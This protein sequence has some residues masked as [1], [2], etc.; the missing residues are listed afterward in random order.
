MLFNSFIFIILCIVTF[1]FYYAPRLSKYQVHI[2]VLSSFVFYSYK[3]FILILLLLFS[4]GLNIVV[5]YI[6]V[7]GK[8]EYRKTV[9]I[10]GVVVNLSALAFFKYSSLIA[11]TLFI[12]SD[13]IGQ[14]LLN[15]PL[16]IGI[17][18]FTFEGISLFKIYKLFY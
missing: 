5:S 8:T 1:F 17:S 16:P 3:S 12:E 14:F 2:L 4:A 7:N 9:A 18:F 10:L 15:I 13:S 11:Q 6:I